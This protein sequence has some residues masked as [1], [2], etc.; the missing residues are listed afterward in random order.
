MKNRK[1][2]FCGVLFILSLMIGGCDKKTG[3]TQGGGSEKI[4]L[5]V[6]NYYDMS[7]ANSEEAIKVIWDKFLS[8]NPDVSIERE[9]LAN[10]PYHQKLEAYIAAGQIPDVMYAW[11]AGRSAN[12][13]NNHLLKDLTPFIEKDDLAKYYVKDALD[14]AI[15]GAGYVAELAWATSSTHAMFV[16]TDVLAECG[17]EPAKT[18]AELKTQ[19]PVLK[20]KGY[21]T[22]IMANQEPW[23]LQSC[24]FSLI[25]GRFCGPG[26]TSRIIS[27]ETKFTD[28]DFVAALGFLKTMFDDQVLAK[29]TLGVDYGGAPGLFANRQS[30]YYIDGDW[31]VGAFITD[32][33]TG[34]ALLSPEQQENILITVFPDIAGAKVNQST[35]W[36]L[37]SGWGMSAAIPAGSAKEDAAWR[38]VKWLTGQEIQSYELSIGGLSTPTRTDIDMSALN[39]EPLQKAIANLPS[40]YSAATK[41]IDD[42]FHSDVYNPLNDGLL[43]I[44]AGTRTPQQAAGD[45]QRAFDIWKADQ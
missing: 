28:A 20:A 4:S 2:I 32:K 26:W 11:P 17:L 12:L 9:D 30:A 6:L 14:P 24:L 18:Y 44:G 21:E 8:D 29:T 15:Q 1:T 41:V 31:R 25:A 42:A 40:Q 27:G 10:E 39:L 36:M 33:S 43:Q 38:L 34:K 3:G 19:V 35:S 45:I 13:Q 22:I 16:N 37:S 23:V 5:R 7:S